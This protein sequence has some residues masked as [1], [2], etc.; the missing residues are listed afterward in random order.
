MTINV[1]TVSRRERA[2]VSV[3]C[4][5]ALAVLWWTVD[6]QGVGAWLVRVAAVGAV[7]FSFFGVLAVQMMRATRRA[8]RG[9][10]REQVRERRRR[11]RE[12]TTRDVFPL[13][14]RPSRY[15]RPWTRALQLWDT[16]EPPDRRR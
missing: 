1:N 9:L 12:A 15:L 3:T 7:P 6:A 8:E 4:I 16:R 2:V 10:T 5:L 11:A 13:L 14:S